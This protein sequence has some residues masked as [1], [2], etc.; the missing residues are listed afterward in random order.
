MVIL[1]S[2]D[3]LGSRPKSGIMNVNG[4]LIFVMSVGH[5]IDGVL[6]TTEFVVVPTVY[7]MTKLQL[8]IAGLGGGVSTL[9][10]A[11]P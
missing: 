11:L 7:V 5:V 1:M 10:S 3:E 2:T 4:M 6:R 9:R 8:T